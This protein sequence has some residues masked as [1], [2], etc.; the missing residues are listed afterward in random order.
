MDQIGLPR[1]AR[2]SNV[3]GKLEREQALTRVKGA[4][5]AAWKLTPEGRARSEEL[6]S[7]MDLAALLAE[8]AEPTATVLGKTPHPVIPPSLAPPVL[9]G[10]LHAFLAQFPFERNVFGMTRFPGKPENGELDP[11]APALQK[12]RAVCELH[13]FVFHLASDRNILDDLWPNVTAHM[14]GCR[15][16]VAFVEERT[17]RGLNYNL[18]IE[19]GS[20]LVLGRRIALLK[21]EPVKKLPTDLVGHIFIEVNLDD[22]STVES[23]LEDWITNT[24]SM[25]P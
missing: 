15:Y 14:W 22:P 24:L 3:L 19:I 21:D 18:T 20:C 13:G 1:P 23:A 2:T 11:I 5:G 4:R 12:A 17:P 25:S 8:A 10:P 6:A 16:G 7:D 9:L